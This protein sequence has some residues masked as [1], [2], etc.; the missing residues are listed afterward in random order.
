MAADQS[1]EPRIASYYKVCSNVKLDQQVGNRYFVTAANA[2]KIVYLKKAE[3]EFLKYTGKDNGNK[4]EREVY[5]KL[6][7]S[8]EFI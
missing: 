6:E 2:A 1:K 5:R 4:L 3:L 7:E 8:S